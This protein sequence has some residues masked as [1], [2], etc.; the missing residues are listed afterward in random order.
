MDTDFKRMRFPKDVV[1]TS[2]DLRHSGLTLKSA[3]K[4][5][6]KIHEMAVKADSAIYRYRF[7]IHKVFAYEVKHDT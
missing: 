7:A 3:R 2:V 1:Y 5:I 6:S 4:N